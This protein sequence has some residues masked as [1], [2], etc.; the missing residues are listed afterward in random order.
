MDK[1]GW[2]LEV[3]SKQKKKIFRR[4][5]R[6]TLHRPDTHRRCM[7]DGK[8]IYDR[9]MA[10]KVAK[11]SVEHGDNMHAYLGICGAYHVGHTV[12]NPRQSY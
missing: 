3:L 9:G 4:G 8:V 10:M 5:K 6:V 2:R 11:L 7:A 1:Y 12:K